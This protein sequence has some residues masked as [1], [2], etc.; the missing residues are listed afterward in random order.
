MKVVVLMRHSNEKTD[1]EAVLKQARFKVIKVTR[2]RVTSD[3]HGHSSASQPRGGG[4]GG[5][6]PDEHANHSDTR[7]PPRARDRRTFHCDDFVRLSRGDERRCLS[8]SYRL[9]VCV[10][11]PS[12]DLPANQIMS[13]D[14]RHFGRRRTKGARR[15]A[16]GGWTPVSSRLVS[17][18]LKRRLQHEGGSPMLQINREGNGES[19][20]VHD[21]SVVVVGGL[22]VAARPSYLF[23]LRISCTGPPS[24]N[25][26][27]TRPV[28]SSFLSHVSEPLSHQSRVCQK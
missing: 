10:S 5:G 24:I 11:A 9:S 26:Q 3:F 16:S 22:R 4:C 18:R 15:K 2:T 1:K 8:P 7:T 19:Y 17:P 13:G 28:S 20:A 21:N 25:T 12:S 14:A 27:R 23:V 6:A